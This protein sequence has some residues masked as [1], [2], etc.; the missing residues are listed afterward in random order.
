[1]IIMAAKVPKK[2][3]LLVLLLLAAAAAVLGVCLHGSGGSGA[4][5]ESR[6][7]VATNADR[8]AFL[9]AY[10]WEV[11]EQPV[12]SQQVLVPTDPGEVFLRY[13][14]LQK[15]QGYDL[16]QYAGKTISRFVYEIKNYPAADGTYYATLLVSNDRVVGADVASGAKDGIMHGL[17][18]PQ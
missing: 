5:Q 11:A 18:R 4:K 10:G 12:Q 13:N 2:K 16:M 3:L 14:E 1:M 8:I 6:Q 15:S 7:K 17:A 9:A